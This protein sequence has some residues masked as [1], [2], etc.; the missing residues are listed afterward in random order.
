[1]VPFS[2]EILQYPL[3]LVDQRFLALVVHSVNCSMDIWFRMIL[4]VDTNSKE[5]ARGRIYGFSVSVLP[6]VSVLR[7]K[8]L[9]HTPLPAWILVALLVGVLTDR[10]RSYVVRLTH[11]ESL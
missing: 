9:D 10:A 8:M 6:P 7:H 2:T 1:L 5:C 4:E 3:Q 11:R